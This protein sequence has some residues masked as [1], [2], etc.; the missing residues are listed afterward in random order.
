MKKILSIVLA[1][2]LCAA[3]TLT[4]AYAASADQSSEDAV[5]TEFTFELKNDPTYTVTVPSAVTLDKDGTQV[6][7]TAENVANLGAKKISVTL[8]GTDYF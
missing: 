7:I 1:V 3:V 5:S 8:A 6:D 4:P 2:A